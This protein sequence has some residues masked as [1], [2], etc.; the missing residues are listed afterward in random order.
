MM[1]ASRSLSVTSNGSFKYNDEYFH[2]AKI[3]N[4]V[5]NDLIED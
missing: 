1:V 2:L 3:L 4:K 5:R